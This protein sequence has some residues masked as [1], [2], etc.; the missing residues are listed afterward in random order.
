M[1]CHSETHNGISCELFIVSVLKRYCNFFHVT[2]PSQC[3]EAKH[4]NDFVVLYFM[5]K[6][7]VVLPLK[8]MYCKMKTYW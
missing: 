6:S 4:C 7:Y 5:A 1:P 8:A 2:D 3:F